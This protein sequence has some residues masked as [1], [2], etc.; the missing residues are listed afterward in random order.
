MQKLQRNKR[1]LNFL[2]SIIKK[3]EVGKLQVFFL[4]VLIQNIKIGNSLVKIFH[5]RICYCYLMRTEEFL[6]S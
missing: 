5:H 3:P 6:I 2:D 4:Q 1:I